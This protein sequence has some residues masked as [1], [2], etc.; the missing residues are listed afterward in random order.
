[1]NK[2]DAQWL[3]KLIAVIDYIYQEYPELF[4]KEDEETLAIAREL[5]GSLQ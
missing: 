1:M 4:S 2:A 5:I 3:A